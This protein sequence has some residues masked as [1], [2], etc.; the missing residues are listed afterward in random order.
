MRIQNWIRKFG[1]SEGHSDQADVTS[2]GTIQV[3]TSNFNGNFYVNFEDLF[4]VSLTGVQYDASLTNVDY[5]TATATFKF[6]RYRIQNEKGAD[7]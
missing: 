7:L 5:L 2:A 4:P 3:L 6:T 1:L